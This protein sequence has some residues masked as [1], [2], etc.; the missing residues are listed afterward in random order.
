MM[1]IIIITI[2]ETPR[3]HVGV[4]TLFIVSLRLPQIMIMIRCISD[5]PNWALILYSTGWALDLFSVMRDREVIMIETSE[6]VIFSSL[7]SSSWSSFDWV[8]FM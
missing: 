7:T 5:T 3:Q 4:V 1:T 8:G 6:G 2:K